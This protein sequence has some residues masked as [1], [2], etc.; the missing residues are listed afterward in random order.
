MGKVTKK[1]T[2]A[3]EE[4]IAKKEIE[5][6]PEERD[7][8]DFNPPEDLEDLESEVPLLDIDFDKEPTEEDLKLEELDADQLE[9]V[10]L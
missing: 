1:E 9:D 5:K 7:F 6:E 10:T 8:E 4:V 2:A 3:S